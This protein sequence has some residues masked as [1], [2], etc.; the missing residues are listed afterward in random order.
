MKPLRENREINQRE[1]RRKRMWV[2][3][4]GDGGQTDIGDEGLE[5]DTFFIG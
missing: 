1:D 5:R 4:R 2:C 3:V